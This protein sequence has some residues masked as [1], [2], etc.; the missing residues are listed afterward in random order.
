MTDFSDA[1]KI[2]QKCLPWRVHDTSA[3]LLQH[4]LTGLCPGI[5]R[6]L[7]L[8]NKPAN[9]A[10]AL[11]DAI[12]IK[13]A[14]Q[15]DSSDDTIHAIGR[16]SRKTT[17]SSDIAPLHQTLE[18]LNKR[19]E[20]LEGT[21]QKTQKAQTTLCPPR[22]NNG[23]GRGQ[24]RYCRNHQVNLCY[25]CGSFGHLYRDCPLNYTGPASP[26]DASWPHHQ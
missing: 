7:L 16:G 19:L 20:S 5:D 2:V 18:T 10:D 3:V 11:K 13:Y 1:L 15:F 17:Q 23:Y 24:L 8:K 6:Q 22:S 12:D 25:N 14:L 21:M 4:F 26:V 9:F